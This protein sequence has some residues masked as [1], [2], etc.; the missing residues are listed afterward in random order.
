VSLQSLEEQKLL[1]SLQKLE[2]VYKKQKEK[3]KRLNE[4]QQRETEL[5]LLNMQNSN[6]TNDSHQLH[7]PAQQSLYHTSLSNQQNSNRTTDSHHLHQPTHQP[8]FS[9][10]PN[11]PH[12]QSN[13]HGSDGMLHCCE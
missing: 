4:E 11:H 1:Q 9:P 8:E 7:R 6:R 10:L 3:V 5:F 2:E 12:Q 13:G